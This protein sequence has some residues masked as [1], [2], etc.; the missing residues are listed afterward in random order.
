MHR[1]VNLLFGC[2]HSR[3]TFPLTPTRKSAGQPV[4]GVSRFGTY[5]TC[6][7]CGKELAYDWQEMRVGG[8]VAPRKPAAEAQ[9]SFR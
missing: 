6:L 4:P 1:V 3:T 2:S 8:P 5:V 9:P 7:D